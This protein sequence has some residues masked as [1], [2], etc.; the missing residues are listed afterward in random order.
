MFG[1]NVE[2]FATS[3]ATHERLGDAYVKAGDTTRAI[4]SYERALTLDPN[5]RTAKRSSKNSVGHQGW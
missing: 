2:A 1:L 3:G 4:E 5:S